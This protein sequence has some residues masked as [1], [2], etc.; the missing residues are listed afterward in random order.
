MAIGNDASHRRCRAPRLLST[1]LFS[2]LIA[3][4]VIPHLVNRY[5]YDVSNP[6]KALQYTSLFSEM[7]DSYLDE[8]RRR[9]E[10]AT[11]RAYG[12]PLHAPPPPAAAVP[13]E[14]GTGLSI[15]AFQSFTLDAATGP[16][17]LRFGVDIQP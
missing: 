12:M 4:S 16:P 14:L 17:V 1:A 7:P 8:L 10:E 13:H 15:K 11:R 5:Q 2:R 3:V 9:E 6:P